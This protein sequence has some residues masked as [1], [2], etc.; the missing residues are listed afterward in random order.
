MSDALL[1]QSW[2][3]E[4]PAGWWVSEKLEGVR[5]V[6]R[7]GSLL[8]RGDRALTC[9]GDLRR[10][11]PAGCELDGELWG[12][13]GQ[14]ERTL[15]SALGTSS[16]SAAWPAGMRFMVF[17]ARK[18]EDG[19]SLEH[20]PFE[21]RMQAA[22]RICRDANIGGL[23]EVIP[24]QKCRS[25][26][27]FDELLEEVGRGGGEGLMLRYPESVYER[28][29]SNSM[30]K[31]KLWQDGEALVEGRTPAKGPSS[32]QCDALICRTPDGREFLLGSGLS[33][34]QRMEPPAVGTVIT[35]RFSELTASN[36]PRCPKLVGERADMTWE[37]CCAAHVSPKARLHT[38]P[39]T[40]GAALLFGDLR[41]SDG[42]ASAAGAVRM[43]TGLKRPLSIDDSQDVPPATDG[44]AAGDLLGG[45]SALLSVPP[46]AKCSSP[47]TGGV[48][49][50]TLASASA[51]TD[52]QPLCP[53]GATCYRQNP[54]HFAEYAHP[55]P[56]GPATVGGG[57]I[58]SS[59]G[60][61]GAGGVEATTVV[62]SGACEEVSSPC[63]SAAE[64]RAA[65]SGAVAVDDGL[66]G[67]ADVRVTAVRNLLRALACDAT[68]AAA[69][70]H[71]GQMLEMLEAGPGKT[72]AVAEAAPASGAEAARAPSATPHAAA[73]SAATQPVRPA[74]AR[75]GQSVELLSVSEAPTLAAASEDEALTDMPAEGDGLSV[76]QLK[77]MRFTAA[78]AA[79]ALRHSDGVVEHALEWLLERSSVA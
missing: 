25:R 42:A 60:A 23:V 1:A 12:G 30:L 13:R 10:A 43:S 50:A 29:R 67:D 75:A 3:G 69:R 8:S 54:L 63:R 17:D 32:A 16:G 64:V 22:K 31:A 66:P 51:A 5:A 19:V 78:Q 46:L 71:F 58:A 28:G 62:A 56:G 15:D 26:K 7:R 11:L 37:Q 70:E 53:W 33:D 24:M 61:S 72:A 27:H 45:A 44:L 55:W 6:W 73:L 47:P 76:Q 21:Q 4:D 77:G 59:L 2:S 14:F 36:T 39:S 38:P 9:P 41:A 65:A 20:R 35:Y 48:A 79:E 74:A 40:T 49:E 68:H 52:E 34:A 18:D 57:L